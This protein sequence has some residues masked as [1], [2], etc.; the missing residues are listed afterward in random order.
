MAVLQYRLENALSRFRQVMED[1]N[2]TLDQIRVAQGAILYKSYAMRVLEELESYGH[3][4]GL[5]DGKED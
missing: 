3:S 2:S 5:Q 1:P 4:G